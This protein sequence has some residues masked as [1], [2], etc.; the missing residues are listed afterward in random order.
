MK[1]TIIYDNTVFKSG[2]QSDW[3]FSCLV[4][5]ENCPK[6]LFDMGTDGDILLSNMR[7]L[8]I[9]PLSIKEVFIS[10][11]HFDHTGG[12]SAFLEVNSNVK[13]YVPVSFRG[14]RAENSLS[15]RSLTA[16]VM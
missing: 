14:I 8:N 13:V 2:L 6:I 5:V 12:L 11:D 4:E 3:G 9:D 15:L 16:L 1:L 10:H 7:K